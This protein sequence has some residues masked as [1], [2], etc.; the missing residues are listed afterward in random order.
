LANRIFILTGIINTSGTLADA[1]LEKTN[2]AYNHS[3]VPG[4]NGSVHF[5]FKNVGP[6]AMQNVSIIIDPLTAGYLLN[7][8]DSVFRGT[9]APGDTIQYSFQF[10]S[11][12]HDTLG[13][14]HLRINAGNGRTPE[15][16]GSLIVVNPNKVFSVKEGNWSNPSTWHNGAVPLNT[17][18][19]QIGH[20]VAADVDASCKSLNVTIAGNLEVLPNKKITILQ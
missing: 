19:V 4:S 16:S 13:R 10:T 17:N 12:Q 8:P 14:Y 11:P 20:K 6:V 9:V 2:W 1:Y 5:T 7:T 18:D 15:V 3:H